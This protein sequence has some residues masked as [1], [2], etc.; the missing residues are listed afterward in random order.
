MPV[1]FP[2]DVRRF[3]EVTR[4]TF[5]RTY[6]AT[7]PHEYIVRTPENEAMLLALARHI[8]EHGNDGRFYSQVRKYH[9]EGGKVYWTMDSTPEGTGLVIRCDEAQ[10]YEARLAAGNLPKRQP[11]PAPPEAVQRSA[12]PVGLQRERDLL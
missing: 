10:T 8:F 7:W 2:E 1:P 9:H 5:A 11:F 6:A 3:V 4:W 12:E